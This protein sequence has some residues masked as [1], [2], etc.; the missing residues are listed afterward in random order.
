MAEAERLNGQVDVSGLGDVELI[1]QRADTPIS[2][3]EETAP[4]TT[5]VPLLEKRTFLCLGPFN[6]CVCIL[7]LNARIILTEDGGK[8]MLISCSSSGGQKCYTVFVRGFSSS[9][10]WYQKDWSPFRFD[11]Y[12]HF[13]FRP[14]HLQNYQETTEAIFMNPNILSRCK[15][16]TV[17]FQAAQLKLGN[18]LKQRHQNK[19]FFHSLETH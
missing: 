14:A 5:A 17:L 6:N 11:K 15:I 8:N 19:F 18:N 16:L 1:L 13:S 7:K 2:L 3:Q 9:R 10:S 4:H 12:S